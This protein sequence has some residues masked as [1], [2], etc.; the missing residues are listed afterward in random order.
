MPPLHLGDVAGTPPAICFPNDSSIYATIALASPATRARHTAC[1]LRRPFEG[2]DVEELEGPYMS[3]GRF[4]LVLV[5]LVAVPLPVGSIS[6]V[7]DA[8][9]GTRQLH[10]SP[11]ATPLGETLN[12]I[13]ARTRSITTEANELEV[14]LSPDVT[15]I[16][17]VLARQGATPELAALVAGSLVHEGRKMGIAPSLLLAV[18]LVENPWIN[19]DTTSHMGAI[20]LM[21]VM[22]FH[23]GGWEGCPDAD[24]TI[25]EVNI[26][27]GAKILAHALGRTGGDLDS[28]LLRY[29]GCVLGT[30]TPKCH[31]YPSW[32]RRARV[33]VERFRE[34]PAEDPV[35]AA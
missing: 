14:L 24:L 31:E 21:Q 27:Y 25:P 18:M 23:A 2:I 19:P 4:T 33:T 16:R 34:A 11:T 10:P 7:A 6:S 13:G 17:R 35:P 9:G 15:M 22:P 32:V 20:G 1:P 29:N 26:C 3:V 30:N 28:A 5:G 8:L 12:D